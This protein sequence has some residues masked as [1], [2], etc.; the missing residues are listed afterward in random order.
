MNIQKTT[1]LSIAQILAIHDQMIK[2]FRGSPGIRDIRLIESAVGR[3]QATYDGEELYMTLFDKAAALLQS[4]L[5]NHPFIDG[6]KRTVLT[7][8]GL[9]LEINGW[10]L[11]N[12]HKEEVQF[13]IQVDNQRLSIEEISKWLE[14]HSLQKTN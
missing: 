1:F 10:K 9:F 2:R 8:A 11:K 12:Q 14:N 5:K 7:A 4:L 3:P 6:N 13:A